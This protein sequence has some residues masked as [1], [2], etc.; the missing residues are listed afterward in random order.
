MLLSRKFG[1]FITSVPKLINRNYQVTVLGG[2]NDV[3]QTIC[4]L[5]KIQQ[6]VKKIVIYDENEKTPGVVADLSHI[7]TQCGVQG[8]TSENYLERALTNADIII[9]AGKALKTQGLSK[10]EIFKENAAFIRKTASAIA[11]MSTMPFVGIATEP[12]NT[13]FPMAVE[14][15]RTNRDYN[16]RK[17]FGVTSDDLLRAQALYASEN[18]LEPY[19]CFI[20][21]I[22]GHSKATMIPLLSQAKP[23][24][25]M[26]E[27]KVIELTNKIRKTEDFVDKSSWSP[28]LATAQGVLCFTQSLIH[29]MDGKETTVNALVENNDFGTSF[30]S[31][32]VKVDQ[33]GAGEMQ[34]Y[35]D[36]SEY[37]CTLLEQSIKQL[38]KDVSDGKRILE[39]A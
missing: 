5:L 25:N 6:S 34:T 11:R 39:F 13:M 18:N 24:C 26:D 37:E 17:V 8:F 9:T 36:L 29:A 2:I 31:G 28:T 30:F 1:R 3:S 12:L 20:P 33:N 4:F 27:K 7:P 32:L 22:G 15:L 23:A 19:N 14:I 16:T 21:V 35:K 10:K 38:R